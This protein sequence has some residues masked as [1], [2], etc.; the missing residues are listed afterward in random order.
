MISKKSIFLE[1]KWIFDIFP[2]FLAIAVVTFPKLPALLVN[3]I[4]IL[5]VWIPS[6][7]L[8]L[9]QDIS[10]HLSGLSE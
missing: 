4:L 8:S 6:F 5:E 1:V 10:S 9:S 3:T 2:L 7:S